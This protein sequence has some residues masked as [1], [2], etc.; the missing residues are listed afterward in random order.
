MFYCVH[1]IAVSVEV[2]CVC[3]S[4]CAIVCG[5]VCVCLVSNL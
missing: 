4:V 2:V 5:L 3:A 1:L